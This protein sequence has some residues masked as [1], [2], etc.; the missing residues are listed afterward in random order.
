MRGV[1]SAVATELVFHNGSYDYLFGVTIGGVYIAGLVVFPL[2]EFDQFHI[3]QPKDICHSKFQ[4]DRVLFKL[5]CQ[6]SVIST[7]GYLE[8]TC[9]PRT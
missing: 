7:S 8:K 2:R 4:G 6:R 5:W 1:C 9:V 3:D